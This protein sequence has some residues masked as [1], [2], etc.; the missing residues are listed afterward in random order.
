MLL[1]INRFEQDFLNAGGG[2]QYFKFF[3]GRSLLFSLLPYP[4]SC[5]S[6]HIFSPEEADCVPRNV[7]IFI[8][9]PMDF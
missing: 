9:K 2:A 5:I 3:C 1:D 8:K 7:V 6:D 4:P